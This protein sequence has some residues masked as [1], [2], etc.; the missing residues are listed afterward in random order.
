M[1][2]AEVYKYLDKY[3]V[4]FGKLAVLGIS[5]RKNENDILQDIQLENDDSI[6]SY[7]RN[8]NII[9]ARHKSKLR[10]EPRLP[11]SFN[12]SLDQQTKFIINWFKE[13]T[14]YEINQLET[15][16]VL[17]LLNGNPFMLVV[18]SGYNEQR[19]VLAKETINGDLMVRQKYNSYGDLTQNWIS[20][21]GSIKRI[22][23][24]V[25][26]GNQFEEFGELAVINGS[27]S[28]SNHIYQ[29]KLKTLT[30]LEKVTGDLNLK[31]T[32]LSLGS[33]KIVEGN[34]NLRKTTINDLGSLEEVNG[35]VLISKSQKD[36][37]D[38]TNVTIR[39]KVRYYN[40]VFNDGELTLPNH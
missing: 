12:L 16:L 8:G 4:P 35:N 36:K 31:N 28:F 15:L 23:G 9:T 1:P 13:T 25:H 3:G 30:P 34:L 14:G 6:E 37:I 11:K 33:L 19:L 22:N 27:L 21:F 26:I 38:L 2:E 20:S 40:D 24:N 39:G 29:T 5:V 18:D 32:H 10:L 7:T 17:P